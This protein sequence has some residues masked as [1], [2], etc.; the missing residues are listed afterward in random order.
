MSNHIPEYTFTYVNRVLR[1][2]QIRKLI[3]KV[4]KGLKGFEFDAITFRGM[5]GCLFAAPLAYKMHK[6]MIMVRK[7]NEGSHDNQRVSGDE[8]ARTYIIVDDFVCSG[9]TVRQIQ[10]H[11]HKWVPEMKCV[12]IVCADVVMD[13]FN[14]RTFDSPEYL[15]KFEEEHKS[16]EI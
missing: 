8:A 7:L 12:G 1:D 2:D 3:P 15:V 14:P 4:M 5:S 10:E 13:E 6:P 16:E 11:I 9:E